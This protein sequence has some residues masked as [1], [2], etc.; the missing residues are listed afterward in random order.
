MP[1]QNLFTSWPSEPRDISY[2]SHFFRVKTGV[3]NP[4]ICISREIKFFFFFAFL[5]FSW[6]FVIHGCID[7]F[8]RVVLFLELADNNRSSTVLRAFN[9][10]VSVFGWPSRVR[11]DHGGENRKVGLAMIAYR[12]RH[13]GSVIMGKSVHNQR[14]ERLWRDVFESCIGVYYHKF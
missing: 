3:S 10:A 9:G 5:I 12:G 7:G 6:R 8:S 4:R 13:R 2:F 11:V 1:A 14:I